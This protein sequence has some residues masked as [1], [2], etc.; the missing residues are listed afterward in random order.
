MRPGIGTRQ[1]RAPIP[2]DEGVVRL[3]YLPEPDLPDPVLE[4]SF[5]E[6]VKRICRGP[7]RDCG[8]LYRETRLPEYDA[9][10]LTD[11]NLSRFFDDCVERAPTPRRPRTD[12]GSIMMLRTGKVYL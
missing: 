2:E 10:V 7:R 9:E 4:E 12:H 8:L 11:P 5:V 6:E 3:P 1:K